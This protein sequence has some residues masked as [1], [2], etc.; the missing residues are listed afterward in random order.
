[1][2]FRNLRQALDR[3]SIFSKPMRVLPKDASPA[4]PD[5]KKPLTLPNAAPIVTA[6]AP[7]KANASSFRS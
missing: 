6:L 7:G 3:S 4:R 5:F 1:M 2:A